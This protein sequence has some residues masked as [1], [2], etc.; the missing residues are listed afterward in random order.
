MLRG[1]FGDGGSLRLRA[2]VRAI[3]HGSD[4]RGGHGGPLCVG[5]ATDPDTQLDVENQFSDRME[6]LKKGL[7]GKWLWHRA[8]SSRASVAENSP[9]NDG[10]IISSWSLHPLVSWLRYLR[11]RVVVSFVWWSGIIFASPIGDCRKPAWW[12]GKSRERTTAAGIVEDSRG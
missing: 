11:R 6:G 1:G 3:A 9:P 12:L 4:H 8:E 5:S 10:T 7:G 2:V